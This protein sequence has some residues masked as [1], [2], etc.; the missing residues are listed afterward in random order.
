MMLSSGS[1]E[2]INSRHQ[3]ISDNKISASAT[4]K[5]PVNNIGKRSSIP[6]GYTQHGKLSPYVNRLTA[7][8]ESNIAH[9]F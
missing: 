3:N 5:K 7:S 8:R 2:I 9:E 1:N 4:M 6:F